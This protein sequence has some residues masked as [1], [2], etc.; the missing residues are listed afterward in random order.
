MDGGVVVDFDCLPI[1]DCAICG[2]LLQ[3]QMNSWIGVPKLFGLDLIGVPWC[4]GFLGFV[5]LGLRA[6]GWLKFGLNIFLLT[7]TLM[8]LNQHEGMC[9]VS[10]QFF[11]LSRKHDWLK[12]LPL[13]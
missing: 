12:L 1:E 8:F 9:S 13:L 6:C 5:K 2:M 11:F 4:G 7:T 10:V 3:F